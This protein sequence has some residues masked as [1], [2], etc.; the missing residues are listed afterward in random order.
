[1]LG[2][3]EMVAAHACTSLFLK[4]SVAGHNLQHSHQ[5]YRSIPNPTCRAYLQ[6]HCIFREPHLEPIADFPPTI[7]GQH[8]QDPQHLLQGQDLQEAHPP[9]GY[10]VQDW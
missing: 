4:Y 1:M 7:S 10:P 6:Y 3:L 5:N 2:M 8:S 9:Q